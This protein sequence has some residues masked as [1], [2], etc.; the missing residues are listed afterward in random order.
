MECRAVWTMIKRGYKKNGG[1]RNVD[2]EKNG[3][4]QLNGAENNGRSVGDNR[5]RKNHDTHNKEE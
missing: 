4:N 3:E 2:I 5:R 1:I